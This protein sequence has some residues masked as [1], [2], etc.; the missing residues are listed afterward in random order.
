[1]PASWNIKYSPNFYGIFFLKSYL[2]C[3]SIFE[4]NI[5]LVKAA[6]SASLLA[7]SSRDL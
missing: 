3:N 4:F 6:C 5:H 2:H 7:C 1:M